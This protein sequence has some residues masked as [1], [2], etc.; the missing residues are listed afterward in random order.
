MSVSSSESDDFVDRL[1]CGNLQAAIDE[2]AADHKE[3]A[4]D[5]KCL[6]AKFRSHEVDGQALSKHMGS[7]KAL[8]SHLRKQL[9]LHVHKK[10][11]N[12]L[13][14]KIGTMAEA[15]GGG[16]DADGA[17]VFTPVPFFLRLQGAEV[18]MLP[19]RA[20]AGDRLVFQSSTRTKSATTAAPS[21]FF[22]VSAEV[23]RCEVGTTAVVRCR[24][25]RVNN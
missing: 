22:S 3:Y 5:W 25:T 6:L 1:S 16:G 11:A 21:S 13:Y 9:K 8:R 4:A 18:E 2:L 17:V 15:G 12:K 20:R 19:K 7:A 10:A 23:A 14:W 24:H